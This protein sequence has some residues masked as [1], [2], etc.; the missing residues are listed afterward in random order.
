MD[1]HH[2]D[3]DFAAEGQRPSELT[4]ILPVI[5]C[6][7]SGTRLW[8]VSREGLPKQFWPLLSDRTMLQDTAL[9]AAA[10]MVASEM[11]S[12]IDF[13]RESSAASPVSRFS[14]CM[15]SPAACA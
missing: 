12:P 6:G 2:V 3:L 8:P 14:T 10:A 5:L 13:V 11:A 4:G 1:T 7:G 15:S 9:R